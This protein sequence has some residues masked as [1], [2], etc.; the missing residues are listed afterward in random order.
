LPVLYLIAIGK[1]RSDIPDDG[2]LGENED[3]DPQQHSPGAV[4]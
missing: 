3:E 2:D 4:R 1:T